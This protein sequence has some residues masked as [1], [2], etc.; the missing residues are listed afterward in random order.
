MTIYKKDIQD[1]Q[2]LTR[3]QFIKSTA[4]GA[5]AMYVAPSMALG[6]DRVQKD[7]KSCVAIVNHK[8]MI[9]SHGLINTKSGRQ[10]V[11][12]ALL[13]LTQKRDI[14]DAWLQIFPNLKPKDTIG[15]KINCANPKCP[16]HP[17]IV[18][19]IA[20]SMIGSLDV[21]PNNIIIWDRSI[22]E[23]KKAG[24]IINQSGKGIR[25][26][27]NIENF[28]FNQL[29]YG[30][31]QDETGIGYDKSHVIDIG[32]GITTYLSKILT[33]MCTYLIN[34]PVLKDHSM[35]GIT[36][37]LKNHYG[38]IDLPHFCHDNDCDPFVAIINAAP[39][40][41]DK[42]R[43]IIC[44]AAYVI[45]TGGPGGLPQA[46][47]SSI[48][49]AKDPVALD[50]TGMQIINKYREQNNKTPVTPA[51]AIHVTTAQKKGLGTCNPDNIQVKK[52]IIS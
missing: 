16:T 40:I 41:R 29:I 33:R 36:L 45:Y 46:Q 49:A 47:Y 43:L 6:A 38:S 7:A 27:G 20:D 5:A 11:D 30:V 48:L 21:N 26:L 24:Y 34:V 44:D 9:N 12:E 1:Q 28:D 19:A 35:A 31:P 8:Q 22:S 2:Q 32:D 13:L 17:E 51:M 52:S 50:Y 14:K 15:L 3:R 39:Q 25:C 37:S 23:L 10:S 4:A 42:T 18:Y